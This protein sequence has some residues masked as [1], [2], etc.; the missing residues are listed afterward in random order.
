MK[1]IKEQDL[2]GFDQNDRSLPANHKPR[3]VNHFHIERI[4]LAKGS[5]ATPQRERF[6]RSIC[7]IHPKA[8]IVKCCDLPHNRIDFGR[9]DALKCH[10]RG[11]K[12][13]VFGELKNAVR[14]SEDENNTCPNY[15]HFSV[16]GFCPYGC[17]YCYL[18]GTQGVWHS[19][20]VKIYVNLPEIIDKIDRIANQL[21]HPTAFYHGKLQDGLALDPLTAYSTVLIPFFA[22]HRFARQII[23]TKSIS[24]ERLLE[25]DHGGHTILTW[26]L[27]PPVIADAYETNVPPVE[28]R[29]E[30]MRQCAEAGY[31]IRAV[32]MPIIPHEDWERLYSQFL[33]ILLTTVPLQRLTIG[34]ICIYNQ[35]RTLMERRLGPRNTI[36]MNIARG[37]TRGDGRA[38]YTPDLRRRLYRHIIDL[39][40]AI[41]PDLEIALCLEENIVWKI[42]DL[43]NSRGCCNCVL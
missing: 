16:Y 25:L 13:L 3:P 39:A 32:M 18:S 17:M 24:V 2:F 30:A 14:F 7:E 29:I 9:T 21:A 4:I 36:S 5:I 41:R 15:W 38:R 33:E 8:Q 42:V 34:G 23:L 37:Y 28:R 6:V 1:Q 35:A 22:R 20:T 40:H 11:K 19:P 43:E 31:P 12:T 10:E 26:S 27:N